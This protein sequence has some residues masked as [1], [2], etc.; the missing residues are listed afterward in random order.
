MDE[1]VR[2]LLEKLAALEGEIAWRER[3][4]LAIKRAL[5]I[6]GVKPNNRTG[7]LP[8]IERQYVTKHPFTAMSLAEA[9]LRV[10][11]DQAGEWLSKKQ[12]EYLLERG[13]YQS[14]AKDPSNSVDITLR[15]LAE[16][17]RCAVDRHRGNSGNRYTVGE[18]HAVKES[19]TTN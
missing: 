16:A 14:N 5:A 10:L 8:R 18:A 17:G 2:T 19:R 11:Q 7:E 12:V 4:I 6:A 9:C 1:T 13:G 3:D 15:N